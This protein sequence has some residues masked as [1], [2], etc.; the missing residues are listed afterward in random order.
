VGRR[1]VCFDNAFESCFALSKWIF[2]NECI[3][4]CDVRQRLEPCRECAVRALSPVH[5]GFDILKFHFLTTM[6]LYI[7]CRCVQL[8]SSSRF[9]YSFAIQ[10]PLFFSWLL[11]TYHVLFP[12]L[13]FFHCCIFGF[14]YYHHVYYYYT[15][16][17]RNY[18]LII[19]ARFFF[20][21]YV[22]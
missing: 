1:H 17:L 19:L 11:F 15:R 18:L 8:N 14:I 5:L 10:N 22:M 6:V 4:I 20:E 13:I 7:M 2:Q 9:F 21:R 16:N 12:L 3:E